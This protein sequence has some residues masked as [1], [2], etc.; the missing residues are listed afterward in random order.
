MKKTI[1]IIFLLAF[2]LL[3]VLGQTS[4]D[5]FVLA[6]IE[7]GDTIPQVTLEEVNIFAFS[8]NRTRWES[9]KLNKLIRNVKRVYPYAKIAGVKFDEYSEILSGLPDRKD[10][11]RLMKGIEKELRDDFE[12]DLRKLNFS[13]G[14]ILI[15]LIDRETG[16][17]SYHLVQD[18]RGKFVAFFWQGFARLF[19][20]NLKTEYNPK[21]EDKEIEFIVQMIESGQI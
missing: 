9:R 16:N 12:G 5:V 4:E 8:L 18:F 20:F 11:R 1:A 21:G 3:G 14:K 19:G 10:Q 7:N 13:Q 15:K 6:R 17:S 2:S